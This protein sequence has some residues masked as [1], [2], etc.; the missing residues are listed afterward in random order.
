[1]SGQRAQNKT[2]VTVPIEKD[3]LARVED[4]AR[5]NGENRIDAMKRILN[6]YLRR[7]GLGT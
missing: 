7:K 4:Y 1:M 3:L 2:R 5:R 6:T